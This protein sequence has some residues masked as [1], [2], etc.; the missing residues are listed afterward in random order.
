MGLFDEISGLAGGLLGGTAG[1]EEAQLMAA[2]QAGGRPGVGGPGVGAIV[3]QLRQSGLGAQVG[4]WIGN[5]ENLPVSA[6]DIEQALSGP[7]LEAIAG[8]LGVDPSTASALLSR[9]LPGLVDR[10]TP[11]GQDPAASDDDQDPAASADD[12]DPAASADGQTR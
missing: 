5:G 1:G 4:S 2:L 3:Q 11:D 10:H 12:Q 9:V 8:R 7:A 6:D